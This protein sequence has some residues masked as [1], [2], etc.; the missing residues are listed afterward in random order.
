MDEN[1]TLLCKRCEGT[2]LVW[3]DSACGDPDHCS[4]QFVC[5][6]DQAQA[7]AYS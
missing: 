7:V 5:N 3:D 2:G 1:P 4:P 6:C